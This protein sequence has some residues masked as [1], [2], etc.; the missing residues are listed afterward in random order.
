MR[1]VI[2]L[3]AIAVSVNAHADNPQIVVAV[4]S[5]HDVS[6]ETEDAATRATNRETIRE[7]LLAAVEA[8][9]DLS[10]VARPGVPARSVDLSIVS[11]HASECDRGVTL[12]TE[13]KIV[14]SDAT[15]KLL[16]VVT[17]RARAEVSRAV[18]AARRRAVRKQL[19][20]DAVQGLFAPLHAHLLRAAT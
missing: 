8:S 7:A 6:T 13:L 14:I 5:A 20:E 15:G 19:L 3:L 11:L 17:G 2:V 4:A 18:F 1:F 16:S 10:T 9:S 12:E